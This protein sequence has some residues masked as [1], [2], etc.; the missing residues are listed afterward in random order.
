[1][2]SEQADTAEEITRLQRSMVEAMTAAA[3]RGWQRIEGRALVTRGRS[4]SIAEAVMPDGSRAWLDGCFRG[5]IELR[6]LQARPGTGAWFTLD[7]AVQADGRWSMAGDLATEVDLEPVTCAAEIQAHPRDPEHVPAWLAA[8]LRQAVVDLAPD[9][10]ALDAPAESVVV[11]EDYTPGGALAHRGDRGLPD[12][13][14][15]AGRK[16]RC[17][18]LVEVFAQR[19]IAAETTVEMTQDDRGQRV[20]RGI[21]VDLVDDPMYLAALVDDDQAFLV[22]EREAD[23]DDV[24]YR[25]AY[26]RVQRAH[27]ILQAATGWCA[28]SP[29]AIGHDVLQ[30]TRL[31][32]DTVTLRASTRRALDLLSLED[33]D[34]A[35]RRTSGCPACGWFVAGQDHGAGSG[36]E[37]PSCGFRPGHHDGGAPVEP[38]ATWR[39]W[40]MLARL[41]WRGIET[42]R[43]EAW[44]PVDQ[45]ERYVRAA[46][47]PGR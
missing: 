11:Q 27:K 35:E 14:Q 44:D 30:H 24:T 46:D 4:K 38:A 19:G 18:R 17:E 9:L 10:D 16:A 42:A 37:C 45:L 22:G 41:P 20:V 26:R 1:M 39:A 15:V 47:E 29:G 6:R 8:R 25:E 28:A 31:D 3:P 13:T 12:A 43:P 33:P 2:G 40:W 23:M 7:V 36:S 32:D 34:A 5:A 21:S